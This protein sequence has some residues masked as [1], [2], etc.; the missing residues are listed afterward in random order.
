MVYSSAIKNAILKSRFPSQALNFPYRC[1]NRKRHICFFLLT[2]IFGIAS[3]NAQMRQV[4]LDNNENNE[5]EKISFFSSSQGY[6]ASTDWIG[7]TSD[8]GRTITKKYVTLSNVDYN[9]YSVNLTFGFGIAGVKAF[10][11]DTIIVYGHYGFV[12][13]ILYSVNQ[14]NN[15]K[16]VYHSSLN[17]QELTKGVLDI[18]FTSDPNVGYAV[19]A[20]RIIKTTNK[21]LTWTQVRSDPNSFFNFVQATEGNV[22]YAM[23]TKFA[24]SKL[25]KSADGGVSWSG[26]TLPGKGTIGSAFFLSSNKGWINMINPDTQ[27]SWLYYTL[28]GGRTWTEKNNAEATSARIGKMLFI[29]DSTGFTIQG[30]YDIYKTT[31][32]GK[33][34]EPVQRDNSYAYLFFGHNDIHTINN[35]QLWAG[36]GHG[37]L[38]LNT[39]LDAALLPKAYFKIDTAGVSLSNRVQLVNYSKPNSQYKWFV[40]NV[41]VGTSYHA[42]YIRNFA[43]TIDSVMLIVIR[44]GNADTLVKFQHFDPPIEITSFSPVTGTIGTEVTINGKDLNLVTEVFFGGRRAASFKLISS[45]EIRAIVS[46]GAS[47]SVTLVSYRGSGSLPGFTYVPPPKINLPVSFEDKIFCKAESATIT[48]QDTETDVKYELIDSLKTV[49]GSVNGNGGVVTMITS[50]IT[51]TGNYSIRASRL[52]LVSVRSFTNSDFILVEHTKSIAVPTRVNVMPGEKLDFFNRSREA[53]TFEWTF[54]EDA[55]LGNSSMPHAE[56]ISYASIGQKTLT[57][58]STSKNGCK[59][60]L[61]TDAVLVYS[62]SSAGTS[63][64]AQ[65][66]NDKD[67]DYVFESPAEAKKITLTRDNGFIITG[68]G[69]DPEMNSEVG[70]SRKLFGKGVPYLAKF[71]EGNALSWLVHISRGGWISGSETD[72]DGNI[73]IIGACDMRFS[74]TLPNGDSIQVAATNEPIYSYTRK[75]NGFLMK[76]DPSGKYLWHRVFTNPLPE[77]GGGPKGG[78]PTALVVKNNRILVVGNST[79]FLTLWQNGTQKTIVKSNEV[80]G[81]NG[82]ENF[83]A[84][85][86]MNGDV[87]WGM[88]IS[89]ASTNYLNTISG[90]AMDGNGNVYV[91]GTFEERTIVTDA[92]GVVYD[93]MGVN[94]RMRSYAF[95]MNQSGKILWTNYFRNDFSFGDI[96]VNAMDIDEKGNMYVSGAASASLDTDY[97]R[98][99]QSDGSEKRFSFHGFFLLKIDANGFSRWCVGDRWSGAASGS[100]VRVD[101][102]NVWATTTYFNHS[103]DG[104]DSYFSSVDGSDASIHVNESEFGVVQYDSSGMLQRLVSSGE[105]YGGYVTPN[106]MVI[107]SKGNYLFSGL[108]SPWNGGTDQ[109]LFFGDTIYTHGLDAF[110]AK[111]SPD[112]CNAGIQPFA[113]AGADRNQCPAIPTQLGAATSGD[114]YSWSSRPYG[115]RSSSPQ[116]IVSPDTTTTYFLTVKNKAG[117]VARD[118]VVITVP[119]ISKAKAIQDLEICA[120]KT[121]ALGSPVV[122]GLQYS[123][124]ANPAGFTSGQANP[125]VTPMKTTSYFFTVSDQNG[126]VKKDTVL[127]TVNDTLV[128]SVTITSNLNTICKGQTVTFTAKFENGGHS[129]YFQWK[130]NNRNEGASE[131]MFIAPELANGDAVSV[132]LTSSI[133]CATPGTVTSNVIKMTVRQV[134]PTARIVGATRFEKGQAVSLSLDITGGGS[135]P[136]YQ[137]EDSTSGMGW[138]NI[139]GAT[140]GTI[141]YI[142]SKSGDKIRC[143]LTSSDACASPSIVYSAAAVFDV[144]T[145]VVNPSVPGAGEVVLFPNPAN[146]Q[147]TVD[148]LKYTDHWETLE[149]VEPAGSV[150]KRVDIRNT[151]KATINIE[152]LRN[153]MYMIVLRRKNGLPLIFKVIKM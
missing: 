55:S 54:N 74:L 40:N 46:D 10:S 12:P 17:N 128:P 80:L 59:D 121:V 68:Y 138:T 63:C 127:V 93:F 21:G 79:N 7:F 28:D 109:Y 153:G 150:V 70:R 4:Y 34:W 143:R 152:G 76:L 8:S 72:A 49:Y 103:A 92:S 129:P 56:Q 15:F 78:V 102:K 73:Y 29:N 106:Q 99:F 24:V 90:L 36:G 107:D 50:P 43:S 42:S 38:E 82:T 124:T 123:W 139:T 149:I 6:L 117:L 23:S 5:I 16:L 145:A 75:N 57:L 146:N 133:G 140:S 147:I 62:P 132:D 144:V 122:S 137:W 11:R 1:L 130:I 20:D 83:I 104:F 44:A 18:S 77:Y 116:P 31:D 37:F 35:S 142:P 33:I 39:N 45:T 14:G 148:S 108:I 95:K 120:G 110:Y 64:F 98:F 94:S 89:N 2:I 52:S 88:V 126:C 135:S 53:S 47:G 58:I 115:F 25:L 84:S 101:G 105:N 9:N 51:V 136:G 65:A 19:E 66:I 96:G 113:N 71:S 48:I 141:S 85:L 91:S 3:A 26:I 118:S 86:D 81:V 41:L 13:A 100:T 61:Q 69:N 151:R 125:L 22:V 87:Q 32:S 114:S 30:L 119:E 60:T 134:I 112:F 27:L 111:A 97:F 67:T 131:W